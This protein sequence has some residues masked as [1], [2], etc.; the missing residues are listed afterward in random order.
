MDRIKQVPWSQRQTLRSLSYAINIP[1]SSLHRKLNNWEIHRGHTSLK[2]LL[3]AQN[4]ENRRLH[5]LCMTNRES[6]KFNSMMNRVHVDEK[7]F[8]ASKERQKYYHLALRKKKTIYNQKYVFVRGCSAEMELP[9]K[10]EF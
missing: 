6:R 3:N 8:F 4:R 1:K 9:A 10:S 2:P 5:G 7:W